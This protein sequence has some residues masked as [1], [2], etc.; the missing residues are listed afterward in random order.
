MPNILL[1]WTFEASGIRGGIP[2]N[3]HLSLMHSKCMYDEYTIYNNNNNNNNN[4]LIHMSHDDNTKRG[5]EFV[6]Y[7]LQH[8]NL[9]H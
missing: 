5:G 3:Y 8:L 7:R 2:L 4:F 6:I 9:N 1:G